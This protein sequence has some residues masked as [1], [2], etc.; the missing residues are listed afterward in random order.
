MPAPSIPEA[1]MPPRGECST[2]RNT[3]LV[4]GADSALASV[5]E[6][7]DYFE[8][9]I[10]V[11]VPRQVAGQFGEAQGEAAVKRDAYRG[12]IG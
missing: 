11:G 10:N 2:G 1:F 8:R 4:T 12:R 9:P 7:P 3:S 6:R 5:N